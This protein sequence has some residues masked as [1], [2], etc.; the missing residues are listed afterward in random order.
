MLQVIF[1]WPEVTGGHNPDTL[2]KSTEVHQAAHTG[3]YSVMLHELESN[4]CWGGTRANERLL[5]G[6]TPLVFSGT[7]H[8]AGSL[9]ARG[10]KVNARDKLGRTARREAGERG[11]GGTGGTGAVPMKVL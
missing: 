10:A 8:V 4:S 5:C 11:G 7:G 6:R 2:V 1:P 9:L 3:S